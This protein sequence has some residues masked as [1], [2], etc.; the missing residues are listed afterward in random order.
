MLAYNANCLR[1]FLLNRYFCVLTVTMKYNK[2]TAN[3]RKRIFEAYEEGHD[4][5]AL[6]KTL[7]VNLRTAY[8]WQRNGKMNPKKK[9]GSISKKTPEMMAA[10]AEKI[11]KEPSCTLSDLCRLVHADFNIRVCINTMKNWLAGELFSLKSIRPCIQNVNRPENK[12]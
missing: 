5:R 4:W 8:D 3:K 10:I 6:A 11:E 1:V 12:L 9:G 7:R 2:I